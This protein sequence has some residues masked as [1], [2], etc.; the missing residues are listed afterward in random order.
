MLYRRSGSRIALTLGATSFAAMLGI[1]AAP[2]EDFYA[3]KTIEFVIG[4][5]V[6]GGYDIYARAIGRH[7]PSFIPGSPAIVPKN[8]PGAGSGRAA[9]F[10]Y[11]LAPKDGTVIGAVFPGVIIAPLF[12][13]RP[14]PLFDPTK[15]QYLGSADSSTRV[16][17]TSE[18]SKVKTF[19]D[20]QRQK[21]I[22]GA[23]AAGAST[24]DYTTM[25]RK[26]AGAQFEMV[27]GY[28]GSADMVLA[29]ER[30]EIDGLCGYDWSS[31]KSQRP[32]WVRNRTVNIL[33]QV[34][35]EPD[36]ELT[37]LGVPQIWKYIKSDEDRKAV[38][39]IVGQQVFGRPYLAPP[40]VPA[41]QVR[42]LRAAFMATLQ[43]KEFLAEA[44]KLRVNVEPTSGEKVQQ[45]VEKTYSAPKATIERAKELVKP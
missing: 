35:L 21:T 31:L 34:S 29:M 25:H 17:I 26:S 45:L 1:G 27:S 22:M 36:P 7:L 39:L 23:S 18:K 16:C 6:G 38:E 11:S 40:G 30:G 37:K 32:D 43:D 3:G 28:K 20:A 24:R 19:E 12:E 10:V 15:L 5:A 41:E 8:L 33:V 2:A 44:E 9:S 4:S 42:I 14:Q 13:N